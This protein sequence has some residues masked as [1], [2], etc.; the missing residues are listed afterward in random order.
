MVREDSSKPTLFPSIL[1]CVILQESRKIMNEKVHAID[2]FKNQVVAYTDT[3]SLYI[4]KSAYD[5]L[6]S[7][8]MIGE[9]LF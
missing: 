2:G 7:Q 9:D 3:D 8:G 6:D 5:R 1:G 4:P